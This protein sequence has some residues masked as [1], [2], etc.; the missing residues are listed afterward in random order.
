[1]YIEQALQNKEDSVDNSVILEHAGDIYA[2]CD[3]GDKALEYWED[4]LKGA[5]D[6]QI[7]IRKIKLKKYIRE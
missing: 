6:K 5:P 2:C 3:E 1:V 7:L 4:A